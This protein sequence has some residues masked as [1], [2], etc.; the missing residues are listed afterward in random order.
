MKV[1][2]YFEKG[3]NKERSIKVQVQLTASHYKMSKR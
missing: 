3:K 1:K 2:K